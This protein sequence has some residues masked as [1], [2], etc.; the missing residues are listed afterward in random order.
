MAYFSKNLD[1]STSPISISPAKCLYT[2]AR[3]IFAFSPI[4]TALKSSE[5]KNSR[6]FNLVFDTS[7]FKTG[8]LMILSL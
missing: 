6:I 5:D 1:F 2:I 4:S 8:T 7:N 3:D